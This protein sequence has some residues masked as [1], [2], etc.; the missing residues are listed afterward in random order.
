MQKLKT[1]ASIEARMTSSRLPGKVLLPAFDNISMLEFMVKRVQ[2]CKKIDDIIIATTINSTDDPI[3]ELCKKMNI[4]Y[5]RGSEDDVLQRVLEAHQTLSTDVIVE[6]TGDCPLIDPCLTDHIIDVYNSGHYDY[7]SNAH[8]RSYPDGFDVQ[9]FPL[10]V[11]KE[12]AAKT[13]DKYDRE[14][15]SSYIYRSGHYILKEVI[16]RPNEYWPELRVTLDDTGDYLL[17]KNIIAYLLNKKGED[18]DV[19]DVIHYIKNNPDLLELNKDARV[20]VALNQRNYRKTDA[21]L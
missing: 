11:L 12:V 21:N 15:V 7:V 3:V 13:Q 8:I 10:T 4:N 1:V 14:N 2:K 5:Y 19:A 18:F 17:I 16:A 9:V 20:N 6:L